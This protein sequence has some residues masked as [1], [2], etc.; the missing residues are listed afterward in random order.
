MGVGIELENQKVIFKEFGQ[1]DRNTLQQG[2]GSGLG[3]W[4]CQK[5]VILHHGTIRFYSEGLGKG[6]TFIVELPLYSK[7]DICIS[8]INNTFNAS[9]IADIVH[10]P[11][12]NIIENLSNQSEDQIIIPSIKSL[13]PSTISKLTSHNKVYID[14]NNSISEI[15]INN[16]NLQSSIDEF[17]MILP[18][19]TILIVDDSSMN[20][21]IIVRILEGCVKI[22]KRC[23]LNL[24]EA[25]D[26]KTAIECLVNMKSKS[27]GIDLVTMDFLMKDMHGPE[28]VYELRNTLNYTGI[29][30]G[31]TGNALAEDMKTFVNKGANLV[32]TKPLNKNLLIN[33][34]QAL[35]QKISNSQ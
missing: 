34:V 3:L 29:I 24:I 6:S 2:A 23:Q 22:T 9:K 21:K 12:E 17:R 16:T 32:L 18:E 35:L 14:T 4:I 28:T 30:I 20:R 25:D 8:S 1:I 5:I 7:V 11:L 10:E 31:I 27:Q 13:F 15:D 26:G 19:L 33:E